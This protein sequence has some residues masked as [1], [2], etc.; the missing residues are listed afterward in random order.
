MPK[1]IHLVIKVLLIGTKCCIHSLL[2]CSPLQWLS[3]PLAVLSPTFLDRR[4]WSSGLCSAT[5]W[6]Y[7]RQVWEWRASAGKRRGAFNYCRVSTQIYSTP[8][9]TTWPRTTATYLLELS[10][11][12]VPDSVQNTCLLLLTVLESSNISINF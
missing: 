9:T 3:L 7:T 2:S 10:H 8:Q 1:H 4:I 5:W 6:C 12:S 11:I